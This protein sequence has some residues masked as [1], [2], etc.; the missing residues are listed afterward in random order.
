MKTY[1]K[2]GE[3]MS[4]ARS[5]DVPLDILNA[6]ED[7]IKHRGRHVANKDV[8]GIGPTRRP[9]PAIKFGVIDFSDVMVLGERQVRITMVTKSGATTL[10]VTDDD[11]FVVSLMALM[12]PENKKDFH[13][14]CPDGKNRFIPYYKKSLMRL[15]S[16]HDYR[17][18]TMRI[19][20]TDSNIGISKGDCSWWITDWN[21]AQNITLSGSSYDA[22]TLDDGTGDP[23]AM[24]TRFY[25]DICAIQAFALEE[26]GVSMRKTVASTGKNLFRRS[27]NDGAVLTRPTPQV[28]AACVEGKLMRQGYL[29]HTKHEGIASEEDIRRQYASILGNALPQKLIL[30]RGVVGGERREGFFLCRVR[31]TG[32]YAIKIAPYNPVTGTFEHEYWNGGSVICWLASSEYEGIERLGY[33]IEPVW[34]WRITEWLNVRPLV[35]KLQML[36]NTHAPDSPT[37]QY[38]K[39]IGNAMI[40]RFST[41][42]RFETQLYSTTQPE[43]CWPLQD[44][45]TGIETPNVWIKQRRTYDAFQQPAIT[46][47]IYGAARTQLYLKMAQHHDLGHK[48]IHVCTDS[49]MVAGSLADMHYPSNPQFGDWRVE[50]ESVPVVVEGNNKYMLGKKVKNM[51]TGSTT[52]MQKAFNRVK[53]DGATQKPLEAPTVAFLSNLYKAVAGLDLRTAFV[54]P[55]KS[56]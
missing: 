47:Y 49:I 41:S 1:D 40:G 53:A 37:G 17:M 15:L 2:H 33:Q 19:D 50:Q 29:T 14:F 24:L 4:L 42:S 8:W 52:L 23:E 25:N 6:F 7:T 43:G 26:F 3:L 10:D 36:V 28:F 48:I 51:G 12:F 21:A 44:P 27:M 38:C 22:S 56:D 30:D 18:S 39:M 11:A 13:W 35:E 16:M 46:A 55:S 9:G 32:M 5:K 34:G 31:G 20:S 54:Q 45:E